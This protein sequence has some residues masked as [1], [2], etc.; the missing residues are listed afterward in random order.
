VADYR[1]IPCVWRPNCKVYA[2][3]SLVSDQVRSQL[4]VEAVMF[5]CFKQ[6]DV[7]VGK[8]RK[9]LSR[10]V[11]LFGNAACYFHFFGYFFCASS[12]FATI[13]LMPRSGTSTQSGRLLSS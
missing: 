10:S 6:R 7:K 2:R 5:A 11:C 12:C 1:H 13:D 8:Q 4:L 3:S 9:P